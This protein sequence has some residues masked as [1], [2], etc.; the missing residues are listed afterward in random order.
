MARFKAI[1]KFGEVEVGYAV[2]RNKKESKLNAC[3]HILQAMVPHLYKD[4]LENKRGI[5]TVTLREDAT[6]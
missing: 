5:S 1:L 3:K 6:T 4:W 2:G